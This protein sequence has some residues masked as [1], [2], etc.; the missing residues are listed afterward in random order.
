MGSPLVWY[1]EKSL[2]SQLMIEPLLFHPNRVRAD[3][4]DVPGL[5][6]KEEGPAAKLPPVLESPPK[7]GVRSLPGL[8]MGPPFQAQTYPL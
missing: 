6:L 5:G 7:E 3:K 8:P 4:S 2:R 1:P